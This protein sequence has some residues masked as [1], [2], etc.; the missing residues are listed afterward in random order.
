MELV[1]PDVVPTRRAAQWRRDCFSANLSVSNW[2]AV[3]VLN[4]RPPGVLRATEDYKLLARAWQAGGGSFRA[5]P[6]LLF[7]QL[8]GGREPDVLSQ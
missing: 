7:A 2:G 4:G 5:G 1:V 8:R 6:A 3:T